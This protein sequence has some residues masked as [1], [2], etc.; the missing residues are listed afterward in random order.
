MSETENMNPSTVVTTYTRDQVIQS[1]KYRP[2]CDVFAVMLEDDK[3][4]TVDQLEEIKDK[5]LK[6]PIKEEINKK[7]G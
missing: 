4:Y 1:Q 6:D 2:Y 3:P 7:E 5:F